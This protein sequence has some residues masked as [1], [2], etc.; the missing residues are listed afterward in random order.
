MFL[1]FTQFCNLLTAY[2]ICNYV[3]V[4]CDLFTGAPRPICTD[5]CYYY[6][7]ECG[8]TYN[9]LLNVAVL[10]YSDVMDNC[11]NTL[12]HLQTSYD[13]PCSSNS[14]ENNCIDLQSRWLVLEITVNHWPFSDRF[15]H[16]AN[17]NPFWL[18]NFAVHFQW[19][20]NQ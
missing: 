9:A 15:Q 6:R 2:V 17:Q 8:D 18:A 14:L 1:D 4:P 11:N 20:S 13:F 12:S 7:I 5:S 10:V 16:L 3:F 19:D